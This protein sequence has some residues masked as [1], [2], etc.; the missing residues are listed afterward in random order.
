M[1]TLASLSPWPPDLGKGLLEQG[2][3]LCAALNS[4]FYCAVFIRPGA[5]ER[6]ASVTGSVKP[7]SSTAQALQRMADPCP[8]RTLPSPFFFPTLP[9]TEMTTTQ[10]PH[11]AY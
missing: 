9:R 1:H 11:S 3:V 2:Q 6:Q 4:L 8:C 7:G 10:M 5:G